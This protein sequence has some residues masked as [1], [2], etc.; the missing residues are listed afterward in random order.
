MQQEYNPNLRRKPETL[1]LWHS[2]RKFCQINRIVEELLANRLQFIAKA[3]AVKPSFRKLTLES[4]KPTNLEVAWGASLVFLNQ[5]PLSSAFVH[6]AL[7][8]RL[9]HSNKPGT[10]N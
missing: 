5:R 1:F 8:L 4:G 9:M 3:E 2:M 6:Q 7:L 10:E